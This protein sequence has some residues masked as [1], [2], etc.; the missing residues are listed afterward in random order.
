MVRREISGCYK[1]QQE[2]L[3]L[4]FIGSPVVSVFSDAIYRIRRES[5][6]EKQTSSSSRLIF[7][8][9]SMREIL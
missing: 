2:L 9:S 1:N 5:S 3:G 6:S 8:I 7:R 4:L